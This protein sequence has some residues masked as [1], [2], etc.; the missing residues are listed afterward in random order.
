MKERNCCHFFKLSISRFLER[1]KVTKKFSTCR[2]SDTTWTGPS[3]VSPIWRSKKCTQLFWTTFSRQ[4]QVSA[5][6]SQVGKL[7]TALFHCAELLRGVETIWEAGGGGAAGCR[8]QD[9][10]TRV[11]LVENEVPSPQALYRSPCNMSHRN[12]EGKNQLLTIK[13]YF[14]AFSLSLSKESEFFGRSQKVICP[15]YIITL[16]NRSI[17]LTIWAYW[18][19]AS[20][21]GEAKWLQM[22]MD[23]WY[24][25]RIL[26]LL[27]R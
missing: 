16:Q 25:T 24:V 1:V 23:R 5:P 6:Q 13:M 22:L 8:G 18:K 21:A 17:A 19:A 10:E 7:A 12:E 4:Q 14:F 27:G 20:K 9:N 2:G 26:G 15:A 3:T 11:S